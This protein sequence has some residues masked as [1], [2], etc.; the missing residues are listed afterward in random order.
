MR[1]S[2]MP[3]AIPH[4]IPRKI[5]FIRSR[6]PKL[7][8]AKA[9]NFREQKGRE[10]VSASVEKRTTVPFSNVVCKIRIIEA[11]G[12]RASRL[13]VAHGSRRIQEQSTRRRQKTKLRGAGIMASAVTA[14]AGRLIFLLLL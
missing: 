1:A 4:K 11:K 14:I 12:R 6:L 5:R 9:L 2:A 7:G 13:C 3:N 10:I 8:E